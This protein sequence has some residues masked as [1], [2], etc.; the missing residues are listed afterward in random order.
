MPGEPLNFHGDMFDAIRRAFIEIYILKEEGKPLHDAT[1]AVDAETSPNMSDV[2]IS[3]SHDGSVSLQ[4]LTPEIRQEILNSTVPDLGAEVGAEEG[5]EENPE[6]LEENITD[7]KAIAVL[8]KAGLAYPGETTLENGPSTSSV[9]DPER[10]VKDLDGSWLDV[11]FDL[12]TKFAVS[13]SASISR[14][15]HLTVP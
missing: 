13:N 8:E 3:L 7:S 15:M 6:D 11:T 1:N 10:P 14:K 5:A 12:E 4:F 9:H 2:Q